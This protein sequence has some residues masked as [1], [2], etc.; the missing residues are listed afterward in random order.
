VRTEKGFSLVEI[1]V[2]LGIASTLLVMASK[3]FLYQSHTYDVQGQVTEMVQRARASL[4]LVT[5]ETRMAGYNPTGASFSG[6]PHDTNNLI[7]LADLNGDGDILDTDEVVIYRYDASD[8]QIDRIT[9]DGIQ[10]LSDDIQ[11]FSFA[12]LKAD[13][14]A[15]TSSGDVRQLEIM[16]D[17]RTERP[18]PNYPHNGGYR[19]YTLTSVVTPKNL[20]L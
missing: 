17:A 5:R 7:L 20:H 15:A 13:G 14:T 16:I 6:V 9:S 10:P 8:G 18:D 2:T 12:H 1:L 11:L 3:T 19:T 4:D